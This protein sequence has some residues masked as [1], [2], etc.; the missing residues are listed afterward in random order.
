MSSMVFIFIIIIM[1]KC[2]DPRLRLL[3]ESPSESDTVWL[4]SFRV[5]LKC[6][7]SLY[8]SNFIW[9]S[10]MFVLFISLFLKGSKNSS[11]LSV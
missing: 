11:Q 3:L 9:D 6:Q 4:K 1:L 5:L 8:I 10:L 7:I 2:D